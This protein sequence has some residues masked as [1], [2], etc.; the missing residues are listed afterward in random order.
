MQT[1]LVDLLVRQDKMTMAHSLENRVPFL[2]RQ[3]VAFARQP[4]TRFLV[5]SSPF[6]RKSRMRNTKVILK[7]LARRTFDEDFVYRAKSGFSLPLARYFADKRFQSLMNDKL[8]PGMHR[9]GLLNEGVVKDWWQSLP[10]LPRGS[11]E[12]VW[13]FVAFELWAQTFLGTHQSHSWGGT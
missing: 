13:I 3:V 11:D 9:R 8:L 5:G 7:D 6:R 1:Y 12:T 4:P 10:N 2:G